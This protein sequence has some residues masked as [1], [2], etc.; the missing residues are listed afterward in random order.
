MP[1]HKIF[2][3]STG[4]IHFRENDRP[5]INTSGDEGLLRK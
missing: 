4:L 3:S 5:S 1:L 2:P